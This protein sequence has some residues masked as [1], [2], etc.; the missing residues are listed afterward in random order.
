MKKLKYPVID[1]ASPIRPD[2]TMSRA[3][4]H[5]GCVRIMNASWISTPVLISH[6]DQSFSVGS[7]RA[8]RLLT[9]HVLACFG[10]SRCPL[11]VQVVR[12]W[13]VDGVDFGIGDERVV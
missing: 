11:D 2:R 7:N 8:D 9:E 5:C 3:P 1:R 6:R 13:I 12:Q 4:S 10:R